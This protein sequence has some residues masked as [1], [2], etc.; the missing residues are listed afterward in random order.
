[1]VLAG[2]ALLFSACGTPPLRVNTP[3]HDSGAVKPQDARSSVI[4][5]PDAPA[6]API[7]SSSMYPGT[8]QLVGGTSPPATGTAAPATGPAAPGTAPAG[9]ATTAATVPS[10]PAAPAPAAP[11]TPAASAAAPAAPQNGFQLSFTDVDIN[12][13][14]ASVLGEALG[15][16]YSI[17]PSLKGT[18]SLRSSRSLTPEELLPALEAALRMQDIALVRVKDTYHVVPM[19]DAPRRVSGINQPADR[20]QPGYSIQIVSLE[21]TSAVEMEK[22][23][24]PFAP[25]GGVVKVDSARNVLVLAGSSQELATML[26]VVKTFD[27]DWLAGMSY[28]FFALNYVD[29]KTVETELAEIFADPKS[30]LA[31]VVRL[32]PL[33]RLNTILVI[34]PQPKYLQSVETWIKRLDVGGTSAGRRIYVYDVQ[35]GR[36]EDLAKSLNHILSLP[37]F[38]DDSTQSGRGY[39]NGGAQL[40][41]GSGYG[42]SGSQTAGFGGSG[43][44]FGSGGGTSGLSSGSSS[45]PGMGTSSQLNASQTPLPSNPTSGYQNNSAKAGDLRIVANNDSNSLL[46]LATPAEFS[47]IEAA[48][49][50]LDSPSRQVLIEASLAEVTLTDE[51]R[52]GVQ[53]SYNGKNGP[54]TLSDIASGR[55]AQSF[56]GLSFLFTGSTDISAV[57]NALESVTKVRVISSPKLVTLNN[58]EASLQVGDQVP[59]TTQ[60]AISTSNSE[61]PIV[62]SVQMRD[63]GVILQVTPRVNK[64]GLVQLDISQE[65]SNSIPTTTSNIDSPT[66]QERKLSSTVVVRNGDTVA[67]G[68][69][70][71]ENIS[72]S[73]SG[74]PGLAKIPLLGAL[75]RDTHDTKTRTELILLITPRVMRDDTEF[76]GVMDDLRGEFQSLK[77]VFQAAPPKH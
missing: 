26:D 8:G 53:W 48:L 57:L 13:V 42:G 76:Q 65:V 28:G 68:G 15:L 10:T 27:V 64:N 66:I 6:T 29:A 11:A 32:V 72:R 16:N 55:I 63:T 9:P 36:A 77:N 7:R 74:V 35:N 17:D 30:P 67:L 41:F 73:R 18:M 12:Q 31:G 71:T 25:A 51:L 62:N 2:L 56:P 38:G 4:Q 40:G 1:M 60:A 49:Q 58:H 5:V 23:L 59:I 37:T 70:I 34:T 50:R 24:Q 3:G 69:L 47:V 45:G 19:K 43:G 22:V 52:Y 46:I 39:G 75:F 61:A 44:G 21:F 54:V 20:R 33:A 14:I